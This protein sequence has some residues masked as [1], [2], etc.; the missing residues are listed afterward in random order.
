MD[1]QLSCKSS[2]P[3]QLRRCA[4][5]VLIALRLLRVG[6]DVTAAIS[7]LEAPKE[8]TLSR[9]QSLWE[10]VEFVREANKEL[11]SA[12]SVA[13]DYLEKSTTQP[14]QELENRNKL[15]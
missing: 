6:S 8:I 7:A 14:G 10:A 1:D 12:L 2:E 9:T 3:L 15:I 13:L 5:R 11:A 4:E